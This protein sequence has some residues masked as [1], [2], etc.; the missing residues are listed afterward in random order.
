MISGFAMDYC[1]GN[2]NIPNPKFT[3]SA[4][5]TGPSSSEFILPDYLTLDDGFDHYQESW[6]QSTESSEKAASDVSGFSTGATS[7]NDNMQVLFSLEFLLFII[8]KKME[9]SF[10]WCVYIFILWSF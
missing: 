5:T 7:E 10:F 1:F 2:P 8:N 3:H 9:P 4:V 6:S